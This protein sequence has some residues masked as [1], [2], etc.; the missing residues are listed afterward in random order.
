MKFPTRSDQVR[1]FVTVSFLLVPL[2]FSH[3]GLFL[4]LMAAPTPLADS[5]PCA[6]T[7]RYSCCCGTNAEFQRPSFPATDTTLHSS[8]LAEPSWQSNSLPN[9]WQKTARE[10]M[11]ERTGELFKRTQK[12]KVAFMSF[13]IFYVLKL[14]QDQG[15]KHKMNK[16]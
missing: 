14:S 1:L 9:D 13:L 7:T 3:S 2:I 16:C 11:R 15:G 8:A 10:P 5:A 4:W 12:A 6:E